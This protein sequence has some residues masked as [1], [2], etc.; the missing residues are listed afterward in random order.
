MTYNPSIPAINTRIDQTYNLITTNFTVLNTVYGTDH[1]AYDDATANARKHRYVTLPDMTATP[2]APAAGNGAM[3][4]KTATAMT[5]PFWRRDAAVTDWP[6]VPIKAFATFNTTTGALEPS[7]FNIA[8]V[9]VAGNT[10]TITFT[11]AMP[12]VDFVPILFVDQTAAGW[13]VQ[14]FATT[15]FQIVAPGFTTP[16]RFCY[17]AVLHI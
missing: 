9:A 15:G 7:S 8:A 3:Y 2:P 13:S 17:F 6:M 4:A 16:G 11:V 5:Y 10:A 1:F 12:T 14:A